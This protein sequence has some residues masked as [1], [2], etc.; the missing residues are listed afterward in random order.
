MQINK[1]KVEENWA[2]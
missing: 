1:R 2:S